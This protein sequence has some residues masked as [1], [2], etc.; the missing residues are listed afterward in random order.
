MEEAKR[1]LISVVI[2]TYNEED[3]VIPMT[4]TLTEIFEKELARYDYEIIYIDNHSKDRTRILLRNICSRNKHV[5]AI[6][7]A[8]NFGQ[9]RSPVHGLKQAYGD[10]VIRL[11]ADFQD[12]PAM[13]PVLVREWEAGSKIVI[14]IKNKTEEG[15]VMAWVRR[16]YYKLLRKIT[17]I[18]HIENFTGFGLYDKAFVDV[19]RNV[20]DPMP[21]LRGMIAELGFDY[22][23]ILYDRPNRRAG[24]SKNNFYTLYDYA[25]VGIT[26]YSKVV[27]RIATFIGFFIGLTSIIVALVYLILKLIH[28]DWFHAGI[29][30]LVI[31]QFFLGGVQLFFIGLMGEYILSINTRVLGRPL[32]VEEERL[33]FDDDTPVAS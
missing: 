5:K 9:M 21:Y 24:K 6:F 11:T 19:I 12:P 7:N 30:P 23:T 22:K 33:N 3:N 28:W 2:P 32:V 1:K 4:E 26:S 17:D 15:A 20:H 18:G 25:M 13:I 27:L 16:Q 8:R 10:C 29:A 31:G 14:G